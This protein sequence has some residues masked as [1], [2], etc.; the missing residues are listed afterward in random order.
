MHLACLHAEISYRLDLAIWLCEPNIFAFQFGLNRQFS[1]L[2]RTSLW[3]C[4]A[5]IDVFML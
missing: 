5:G 3:I 2:S 1:L 4:S